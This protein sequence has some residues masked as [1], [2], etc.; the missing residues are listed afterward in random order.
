MEKI[1][2]DINAYVAWDI[3]DANLVGE[4]RMV[5]V[6]HQKGLSFDKTNGDTSSDSQKEKG[7]MTK[8]GSMCGF[9]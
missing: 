4:R 3:T 8:K 6:N 2:K 9:R 5:Y 7:I 1:V